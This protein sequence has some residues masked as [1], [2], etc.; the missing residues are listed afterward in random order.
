MNR[1]KISTKLFILALLSSVVLVAMG[2]YNLVNI[3]KVNSSLET[4][5]KDRVVGLKQLN[6][7]AAQYG[8][9]ILND[10]HKMSKGAL[11]F[12]AGDREIKAAEQVIKDSWKTYLTADSTPEEELIAA[13]AEKLMQNADAVLGQLHE[14]LAKGDKKALSVFI[15]NTLHPAIDPTINKIGQLINIQMTVAEREYQ[16]GE[17]VYTETKI[18]ACIFVMLGI[19]ISVVV[20]IA[21]IKS[22]RRSIDY[23]SQVI[24]RLSEGDLTVDIQPK[25]NDEIGVVLSDLKMMTDKIKEVIV[26]V[27]SASDHIVAASQELS[28]SSEQMSEGATEQAAATEQVSS[29]M[30]EMV[31]NVQQSAENAIETKKIAVKASTDVMNG[32][33]A[34]Q[35]ALGSMRSIADKI[36]VISEI[37][38]Q[39]NI[40]ALNA[41][42]EAARAGDQGRGFA[43]VAAE[44]RKLAEKSQAAATEII[45]LSRSGVTIAEKSGILLGLIVPDIQHTARLVE[46]ISASSAEQNLGAE[47]INDAMQQL[48]QVTQQNAATSE[49]MAASAEELSAQAEQLK[50]MISFFKLETASKVTRTAIR[51][52][53]ISKR[54]NNSANKPGKLPKQKLN[55]VKLNMDSL[56]SE[57]EKF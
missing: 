52:D 33:T 56:D 55:G 9:G 43:V 11:A 4:I 51:S 7:I 47:Q 46:E 31:A 41:A 2:V 25:N 21:I 19:V 38:R 29:S 20:S 45:E 42:V 10:A 23:A 1:I 40:L 18:S 14:I 36:H 32:S 15:P 49:E 53:L 22:I 28:A 44:V 3:S 5:Y 27:N 17:A 12:K 34:V 37:A 35:D 39:T 26:Y 30:E 50:D 8:I 48:N 24:S 16:Q 13:D 54:Y 57:Y 6:I